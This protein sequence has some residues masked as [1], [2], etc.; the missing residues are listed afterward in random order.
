M[1]CSEKRMHLSAGSFY[2]REST[3]GAKQRYSEEAAVRSAE[4]LAVKWDKPLDAYPCPFCFCWH[5]GRAMTEKERKIFS[6]GILTESG[7]DE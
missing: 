1:D 2:G 5:I 3:C 7:G 6:P 4:Y